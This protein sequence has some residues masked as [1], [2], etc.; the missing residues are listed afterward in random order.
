MAV[1]FTNEEDKRKF[2]MLS[3]IVGEVEAMADVVRHNGLVR[4]PVAV[5]KDLQ[6]DFLKSDSL[7]IDTDIFDDTSEVSFTEKEIRQTFENTFT[8]TNVENSERALTDFSKRLG[9]PVKFFKA[10]L[11]SNVNAFYSAG[12]VYLAEGRFSS[13]NVFHEFAHPVIKSLAK[14]NIELFD[15]LYNDLLKTDVGVKIYNRVEKNYKNEY[16]KDSQEFREEVLVQALTEANTE[17]IEKR[18]AIGNILYNVKRILRKIFGRTVDLTNLSGKTKLKDF[19]GMINLDSFV[20]DKDFLNVDD[21]VYLM[22]EY[23]I[24][25]S[26]IT[27]EIKEQAQAYI[28]E[29]SDIVA[30]QSLYLKNNGTLIYPELTNEENN[31]IVDMM[32]NML[33][34]LKGIVQTG[35]LNEGKVISQM[36]SEDTLLTNEQVANRLNSFINQVLEIKTFSEILENKY[37]EI[38]DSNFKDFSDI[39]QLFFMANTL[40]QYKTFLGNAI[41]VDTPLFKNKLI[42][43]LRETNTKITKLIEEIN[44]VKISIVTDVLYEH[45]LESTEKSRKEYEKILSKSRDKTLNYDRNHVEYYGL[46]V[47]ELVTYNNLNSKKRTAQE[48]REFLLLQAKKIKGFNLSKEEFQQILL[49]DSRQSTVLQVLN[50]NYEAYMLNQDLIVGTYISYVKSYFDKINANSNSRQAA[51]LGG[52]KLDDLLDAAK[53]AGLS[54]SAIRQVDSP[55]V[56]RILGEV[57]DVGKVN[58]KEEIVENTE[59]QFK[60]ASI[61]FEIPIKKLRKKTIDAKNAFEANPSDANK[62]IWYQAQNELFFELKN[63]YVQQY[64]DSFY[65]VEALLYQ[66]DIGTEA[67]MLIDAIYEEINLIGTLEQALNDRELNKERSDKFAELTRLKSKLNLD[68]S[69]KTGR[70]LEIAERLREY[71]DRKKEGYESQINSDLFTEMYNNV[72]ENFKFEIDENGNQ[73]PRSPIAQQELLNQWIDNNTTVS[74]RDEFYQERKA[75][76]ERRDAILAPMKEE[77]DKIVDLSNLY[78]QVYE[79][80]RV[81]RDDAGQ[82]NGFELTPDQQIKLRDIQQEIEESRKELYLRSGLTGNEYQE[83]MEL[84]AAKSDNFSLDENEQAILDS[85]LE[86]IKQSLN[87]FGIDEASQIELLDIEKLISEMSQ[88]I[89]TNHYLQVFQELYDSHDEFKEIFDKFLIKV[90]ENFDLEDIYNVKEA[91]LKELFKSYNANFLNDLID[92]NSDFETFINN[93]HIKIERQEEQPDGRNI[94]VGLLRN[95]SVWQ[96]AQPLSQDAYNTF[97]IKDE[98]GNAIDL[99]R[100][101][102]NTLRVPNFNFQTRGVKDVFITKKITEDYVDENDNLVIRNWTVKERWLPKENSKYRNEEYFDMFKNNRPLWNLLN[103][104]KNWHLENQKGINNNKKLDISYPRNRMSS[105]E[106][107][108]ND[109]LKAGFLRRSL[110]NFMDMFRTR[111]DDF[112]EGGY[113]SSNSNDA[114]NNLEELNRVVGGVYDDLPFI[115]MSTD[116][117]ATSQTYQHSLQEMKI[118][119]SL[120]PM[121]RVVEQSIAEMNSTGLEQGMLA[122]LRTV[123]RFGK[124]SADSNK[125]QTIININERYL[126]GIQLKT[127][128]K[129]AAVWGKTLNKVNRLTARKFFAFNF[130]A[131]VRNYGSGQIQAAILLIDYKN[132]ITPVNLKNG[133]KKSELVMA[134]TLAMTYSAKQRTAQMQLMDILNASPEQYA[135]AQSEAGSR[136]VVKDVANLKLAYFLR[137]TR[138]IAFNYQSM[139][140]L[141][142]NKKYRFKLNGK[143]TSLDNAIEI[144]DGRIQTKAGVPEEFSISYDANGNVVF[145][146]KIQTLLNA[147]QEYLLRTVGMAGRFNEGDFQTRTNLGKTIFSMMKFFVPMGMFR[148]G[149]K[150]RYDKDAPFFQKLKLQKRINWFTGNVERGYFAEVLMLGINIIEFGFSGF[151]KRGFTYAQYVAVAHVTLTILMTELI[152]FTI[153]SMYMTFTN[154]LA[155]DDDEDKIIYKKIDDY[156]GRR[157]LEFKKWSENVVLPKL[158]WIVDDAHGEFRFGPWAKLHAINIL[159]EIERENETF[160]LP[161]ITATVRGYMTGSTPFFGGVPAEIG[162]LIDYVEASSSLTSE[163]ETQQMIDSGNL[164]RTRKNRDQTK[165]GVTSGP[166][167]GQQKGDDKLY[168]IIARYFGTTGMMADP[169]KKI[170]SN[171]QYLPKDYRWSKVVELG[172]E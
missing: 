46:S 115:L 62:L 106:S 104:I 172:K 111:S 120:F 63:E 118:A 42:D 125:A 19:V 136:N 16:V 123:A 161:D 79:I 13:D 132:Y 113:I 163:D 92:I 141:M 138:T 1:C 4:S 18:T 101:R 70:D 47:E 54:L 164:Y 14:D 169:A 112:E 86:T 64:S 160:F 5:V 21:V 133:Y 117:L 127:R 12:V 148:F 168:N 119:R 114:N 36:T 166:Y 7:K 137:S 129:A 30:N 88:T 170:Q 9:V 65:D 69:F 152:R 159:L 37:N 44:K 26:E 51:L 100:D 122:R 171:L 158:P 149:T 27:N 155:P 59:W 90:D 74:V 6:N 41:T 84:W 165:I 50:N 150:V 140:A 110:I 124:K 76:I 154:L 25:E 48:D 167:V 78:E 96:F 3:S 10:K 105:V 95:T 43:N 23:D 144:V 53:F 116:I 102:N 87:N 142:D 20:L 157:G 91:H 108:F 128:N 85:F 15:K 83:F 109:N 49:N 34:S 39:D 94:P 40:D 60:S 156:G 77:N 58:D 67:R 72:L 93:N 126:K 45:Y 17:E 22:K 38:K 98:F 107:L 31:G 131:S 135:K 56:G 2:D 97:T 134:S 162:R 8:K 145:G 35:S 130:D 121:S 99:L 146:K 33:S 55:K 29:L 28:S 80:I 75:L 24:Q 57:V 139:Y 147:H 71:F 52:N 82:Y 66:D 151:K 68:L 81:T 32:N 73:I 61:D 11:G 89:F 143:S 103:Y 153:G